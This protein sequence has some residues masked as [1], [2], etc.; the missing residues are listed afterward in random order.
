MDNFADQIKSLS[1]RVAGLQLSAMTEEATKTSIIMPFFQVLGYDVFNPDEFLPEFVAD[2]GI[3]KGE[4][5]DFAI[6]RDGKPLILIEA[7]AVS[8]KL[9]KHDSQLYRYFG[10]TE[11]KFAILTNGIIYRFYTDLDEEN[12]MDA[13]PFFEFNLIDARDNQIQELTKFRKSNFDV[14]NVLSSA[15]DLKYTNEI[16]QFLLSQLENPS[17]DFVS[18]AIK[19]I[20]QGRKTKN[21]VDKFSALVK[22]SFRQIVSEQVSDKL[23]SALENSKNSEGISDDTNAEKEETDALEKYTIVTTEEEIEGYVLVKIILKDVI[24]SERVF[25][26]DNQSYFNIILDNNIRKWICRLGLN[27][28]KKYIQIRD[29]NHTTYPIDR[30][31]DIVKFK[32][33]LIQIAKRIDQERKEANHK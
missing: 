11:A 18:L 22:K 25:Y 10:T 8:E 6:L 13:K 21:I 15:S 1:K 16:K 3:K 17:D 28:N 14:E 29:E 4:K 9:E 5:V 30:V 12:K 26:R 7:K 23:A 32:D 24:E 19:D 33:Q 27:R 31:D 20:Y 2:V